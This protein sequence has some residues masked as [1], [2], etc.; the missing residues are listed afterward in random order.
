MIPFIIVKTVKGFAYVRPE[1]VVAI[2]ASDADDCL[3]LMTDGVTI[4]APNP[5]RIRGALKRKPEK[6]STPS[7]LLRSATPMAMSQTEIE[8]M[9]RDA[10]PDARVE[11]K[12][13]AGD[14]NHYAATVVTP[15]FKGK[16]RVRQH[17]MVYEA[18]KGRMGGE[19]HAL[20]LT[21]SES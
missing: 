13:L 15:A 3:I 8:T 2:N 17:Q 4:A 5:P 19:L 16:T 18:L 21:T 14:G 1:R 7:K 10:F 20:A 12:D 6:R 9:I 11:V